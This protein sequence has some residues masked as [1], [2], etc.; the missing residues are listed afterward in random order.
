MD[1]RLEVLSGEPVDVA[2]LV[3]QHFPREALQGGV[4]PLRHGQLDE[5]PVNTNKTLIHI[6]ILCSLSSLC[7][8]RNNRPLAYSLHTSS[9][10]IEK[11]LI[12]T[13]TPLQ[14]VRCK[15]TLLFVQC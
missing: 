5:H 10:K 9:D 3:A 13:K 4:H 1:E 15:C 12:R 14:I 7:N 11:K 8:N 2:G 6:S